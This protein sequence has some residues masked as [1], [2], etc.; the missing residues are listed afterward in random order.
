LAISDDATDWWYD[1]AKEFDP[2]THA[3]KSPADPVKKKRSD[4]YT[5][6]VWASSTTVGFGISSGRFVVAWFCKTKGNDPYTP[7]AFTTN[8]K[9]NCINA[10]KVN[11]CFNA[12]NLKKVNEIR[13]WHEVKA[14]MTTNT[15]AAKVL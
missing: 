14:K 12:L 2:A 10:D 8:V 1:G 6:L 9:K 13:E 7:A 4:A 11:D 5:R 3:P 15:A